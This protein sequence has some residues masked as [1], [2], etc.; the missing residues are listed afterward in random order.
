[1][2]QL[3]SIRSISLILIF[4]LIS[5]FPVF[6]LSPKSSIERSFQSREELKTYISGHMAN[7]RDLVD[8][9]SSKISQALK[10]LVDLLTRKEADFSGYAKATLIQITR[11]S[12]KVKPSDIET[13][14]L[15]VNLS[16]RLHKKYSTEKSIRNDAV[17]QLENYFQLS[18]Y[19]EV[20]LRDNEQSYEIVKRAILFLEPYKEISWILKKSRGML[21]RLGFIIKNSWR[22]EDYSLIQKALIT[23]IELL[24]ILGFDQKLKKDVFFLL[25]DL[26][27][28]VDYQMRGNQ[29][30][31]AH[32]LLR[33]FF[34]YA[35]S[36]ETK[37][38]WGQSF[39]SLIKDYQE[40]GR[41]Y[42]RGGDLEETEQIA[43]QIVV[44]TQKLSK[45]GNLY[46]Y[47]RLTTTLIEKFLDSYSR[48]N[49]S[50][51]VE[52]K[53]AEFRVIWDGELRLPRMLSPKRVASGT[54]VSE[55]GNHTFQI[56]KL[57]ERYDWNGALNQTKKLYQLAD[58]FSVADI[59]VERWGHIMRG[60]TRLAK[61]FIRQEEYEQ[62]IV[63]LNLGTELYRK[64]KDDIV[65]FKNIGFLIAGYN[66][67]SSTLLKQG[68]L[69]GSVEALTGAQ[70][71]FDLF[72]DSIVVQREAEWLISGWTNVGY[73]YKDQRDFEKLDL[74]LALLTDMAK[75]H[76]QDSK[77][78]KQ[79]PFLIRNHLALI[80]LY[81]KQDLRTL[82]ES[83]NNFNQIDEMINL[84]SLDR[85]FAHSF[86]D[87][88]TILI[89]GNALALK[90]IDEKEYGQ[91]FQLLE[92]VYVIWTRFYGYSYEIEDQVHYIIKNIS[93]LLTAHIELKRFD[94]AYIYFLKIVEILKEL[95]ADRYSKEL[96]QQLRHEW[97][98]AFD[99]VHA[100]SDLKNDEKSE[101]ILLDLKEL[102]LKFNSFP[103]VKSQMIFLVMEFDIL[104]NIYIGEGEGDKAFDLFKNTIAL[105]TTEFIQVIVQ[106]SEEADADKRFQSFMAHAGEL[107]NSL[108]EAEDGALVGKAEEALIDMKDLLY[109]VK[110]FPSTKGQ[111]VYVIGMFKKLGHLYNRLGRGSDANAAFD[112]VRLL[113]KDFKP[114]QSHNRRHLR[115]KSG[116]RSHRLLASSL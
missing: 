34:D 36:I 53:V 28:L 83:I 99:L 7:V 2:V 15:Y 65:D 103:S 84:V 106:N 82:K 90:L 113:E 58:Q 8:S 116:A 108:L 21:V 91:S 112:D 67:V 68:Q 80:D 13:R 10:E 93:R 76:S 40:L 17:Y 29:L 60:T 33:S 71:L 92:K 1:M 105:L 19:F 31:K 97:F 87:I 45:E 37:S 25:R 111:A 109:K 11:A 20:A 66:Q 56:K 95:P 52:E 96:D 27:Q 41:A 5:S 57:I 35:H 39:S 43:K 24:K 88:K 12:K 18:K 61:E 47:D 55:I 78:Q 30:D 3:F 81:L 114:K 9:N 73:K 44:V 94:Q 70:T 6:A 32:T 42:L 62:A 64:N 85:D 23:R 107:I 38:L 51:K 69:E 74:L 4:T 89:L 63:V 75:K 115:F 101:V 104:F 46:V 14:L 16:E 98:H 72:S 26:S 77:V 86:S 54:N 48:E 49:S 22:N 110:G 59:G 100:F 102:F 79:L 50:D